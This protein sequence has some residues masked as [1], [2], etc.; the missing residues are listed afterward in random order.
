MATLDTRAGARALTDAGADQRLADAIT[1]AVREAAEHGD[2]VTAD[3]FKAGLAELRADLRAGLADLDTR[4]ATS[5]ARL[6]WRIL[7]I[8]GVVIAVL[9]LFAPS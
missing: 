1:N 5:E 8:A 4:I 9:R 7:G 6:T 3:Q 2:H